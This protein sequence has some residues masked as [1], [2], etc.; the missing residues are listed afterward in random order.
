VEVV[1]A[2]PQGRSRGSDDWEEEAADFLFGRNIREREDRVSVNSI[3]QT[4]LWRS[5]SVEM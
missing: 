2:F 5:I 3:E 1:V 4:E